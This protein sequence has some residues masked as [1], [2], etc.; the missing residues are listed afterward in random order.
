ME[1]KESHEAMESPSMMTYIIGAVLVLAVITGAWYFRSKNKTAMTEPTGSD[2]MMADVSPTPGPITGL[3]C[4]QQY[5]NPKIAFPEYYLSA[6]GG[7]V[8]GATNVTC[9]FTATVDGEEVATATVESPLTAAPQRNG[10]T[11]RCTTDAVELTPNVETVIDVA[12]ADDLGTTSTCTAAFTF[13][14]P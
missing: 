1:N 11:F 9:T 4:D 14:A 6:E 5:F 12:L 13:P 7:D 2:A 8:S 3:S 10:S